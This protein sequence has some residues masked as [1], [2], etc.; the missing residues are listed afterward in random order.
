MGRALFIR[1][2]AIDIANALHWDILI[3]GA[4]G[5]VFRYYTVFSI[6]GVMH[7]LLGGH[8]FTI[9]GVMY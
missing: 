6:R 1:D 9:R 3:L 8:A 7:S 2:N 5:A 4:H